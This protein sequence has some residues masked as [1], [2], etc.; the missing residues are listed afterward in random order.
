MANVEA[1]ILSDA[2]KTFLTKRG[3]YDLPSEEMKQ[4]MG[5]VVFEAFNA[6]ETAR[7]K[8]QLHEIEAEEC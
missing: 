2:I 6:L 8:V 5:P 4:K 3:F 7:L 1:Q